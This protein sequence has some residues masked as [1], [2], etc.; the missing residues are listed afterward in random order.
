MELEYRL[1]TKMEA[2]FPHSPYLLEK[3]LL[4]IMGP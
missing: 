1:E 2:G 4:L 3:S